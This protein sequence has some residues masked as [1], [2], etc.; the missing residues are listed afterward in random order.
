MYSISYNG[1]WLGSGS[2]AVEPAAVK[3]FHGVF[4]GDVHRFVVIDIGVPSR[5]GFCVGQ[6]LIIRNGCVVDIAVVGTYLP[7]PEDVII[8]LQQ[9]VLHT[10]KTAVAGRKETVRVA[11]QG[12]HFV[13]IV[14][15]CP[16]VAV[17]G[18]V[19]EGIVLFPEIITLRITFLVQTGSVQVIYECIGVQWFPDRINLRAEAVVVRYGASAEINPGIALAQIGTERAVFAAVFADGSLVFGCRVITE[20]LVIAPAEEFVACSD[21]HGGIKAFPRPTAGKMAFNI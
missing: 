13:L 7:A 15:L 4:V 6:F 21:R 12:N 5:E 20:V 1:V 2:A 16:S 17:P 10:Q 19:R 18:A 11:A 9:T 3:S 14:D 8:G